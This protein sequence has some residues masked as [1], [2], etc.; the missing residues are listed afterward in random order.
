MDA[1]WYTPIFVAWEL[2]L[3]K[4]WHFSFASTNIKVDMSILS[5][6]HINLDQVS[7]KE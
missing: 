7:Y 6:T 1:I 4:I 5:K 3:N 2:R